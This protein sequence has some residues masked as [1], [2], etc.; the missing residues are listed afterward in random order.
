MTNLILL[1]KPFQVM[2]Q[3]TDG[4][5]RR[6][7]ADYVEQ[8]GFYPA[9][10]LDF[11]S[12]GLVLLTNNGSL[13]HQIADPSHK[14][15][16]TYWVQVEGNVSDEAVKQLEQGV[17]LKDGL[18]RPAK[19]KR[20]PQP[21]L[22]DRNPPVRFRKTVPDQWLELTITEGK[23]RQVRRMTAAV[24][25]PTLRLIRTAIG[26]WQLGSLM[27]GEYRMEQ[28]QVSVQKPA[29]TQNRPKRT[30]SKYKAR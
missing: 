4:D 22:W 16:K 26:H 24:G 27:P 11:D 8:A 10:R 12:E 2:C 6:T 23:N 14:L 28:A 3:F 30:G 13:Q 21:Q 17:V 19:A 9:G 5:G 7:L 20:I 25:H 1:N 18:T 29:R 15:P